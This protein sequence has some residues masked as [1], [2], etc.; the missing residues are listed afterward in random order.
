MDEVAGLD[1]VVVDVAGRDAR[2]DDAVEPLELQFAVPIAIVSTTVRPMSLPIKAMVSGSRVE[3]I[4]RR[5][6]VLGVVF[7]ML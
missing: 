1:A 4:I 2:V 3:I 6:D 7:A 5:D